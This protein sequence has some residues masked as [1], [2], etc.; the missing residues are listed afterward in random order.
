MP[1]TAHFLLAPAVRLLFEQPIEDAGR[2]MP[3]P[4]KPAARLDYRKQAG[5]L[6]VPKRYPIVLASILDGPHYIGGCHNENNTNHEVI[7]WIK[8]NQGV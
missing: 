6:C 3:P 5:K 7:H 2:W 4:R 1:A 8:E